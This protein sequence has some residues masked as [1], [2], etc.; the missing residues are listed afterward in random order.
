MSFPECFYEPVSCP[1]SCVREEYSRCPINPKF[2]N[3]NE[4]RELLERE[5]QKKIKEIHELDKKSR[6]RKGKK[7]FNDVII[8]DKTEGLI[9]PCCGDYDHGNRINGKPFCVRCNL[10]LMSQ[11]K[12]DKRVRS[13]E[14][15]RFPRGVEEVS[16]CRL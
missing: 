5:R 15:K 13:Q 2:R 9:C 12:A 11:K 10:Q 8:I 4:Y 16:T 14:I 6:K 3:S 7:S 1:P